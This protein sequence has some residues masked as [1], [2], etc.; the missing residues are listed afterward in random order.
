MVTCPLL[1]WVEYILKHMAGKPEEGMPLASHTCLPGLIIT[2]KPA[3]RVHCVVQLGQ[4]QL[5]PGSVSTPV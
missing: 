5:T 4:E 2:I 3:V 1:V